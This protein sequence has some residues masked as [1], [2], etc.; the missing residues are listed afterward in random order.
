MLLRILQ[1]IKIQVLPCRLVN[2][3]YRCQ[4][5]GLF[6]S[7]HSTTSQKTWIFI[8]TAVRTS[9][10]IQESSLLQSKVLVKIGNKWWSTMLEYYQLSQQLFL[11]II[12]KSGVWFTA[13]SHKHLHLKE[14]D[15]CFNMR[16]CKF[17]NIKWHIQ[18]TCTN[19]HKSILQDDNIHPPQRTAL[20]TK[21]QK[22]VN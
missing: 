12:M 1:T 14:Q 9:N 20:T 3:F 2:M 15:I 11:F 7:Q 21:L 10:L 5:L 13:L 4:E 22:D 6:S 19:K 18:L 8:N 16:I 17:L